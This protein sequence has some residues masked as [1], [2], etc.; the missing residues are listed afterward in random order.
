M[1]TTIIDQ[2]PPNN[3]HSDNSHPDNSHSDNFHRTTLPPW[4]FPPDKSY[5]GQFIPAQ[6]PPQ[7]IVI[8]NILVTNF[9]KDN[10]PSMSNIYIYMH[11]LIKIY[12]ESMRKKY[13]N[14][15]IL[16]KKNNQAYS[17]SI[18]FFSIIHRSN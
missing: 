7:T 14:I 13:P 18:V 4:H 3:S 10:S 12:F 9:K 15:P 8:S 11:Q 16:E 5:F 6:L 2:L 1:F 17:C